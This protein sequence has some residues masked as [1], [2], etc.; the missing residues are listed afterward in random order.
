MDG[1]WFAGRRRHSDPFNPDTDG[2]GI[3]DGMEWGSDIMAPK[4]TDGDGVPDLFDLD[5]DN[6]G[7]PDKVDLSPLSTSAH[8][9]TA[10]ARGIV[11]TTATLDGNTYTGGHWEWDA[12]MLVDRRTWSEASLMLGLEG[13]SDNLLT[14]MDL[15]IRPVNP[16]HLWYA[17]NVLDWPLDAMGQIQDYDRKTFFDICVQQAL[18]AGEDPTAKCQPNPNANGDTKMVPMVEIRFGTTLTTTMLILP[19]KATLDGYGISV[20]DL[21]DGTAA[22]YLPLQLVTDQT[23]GERVAFSTRLPALKSGA[24]TNALAVQLVWRVQAL[25]DHVCAEKDANGDCVRYVDNQQGTIATYG[26][27]WFLTGLNVTENRGVD[28]ALIYEDPAVDTN[29]Q[30]DMPLW[31]LAQALDHS[32]MSGRAGA[33]AR[34]ITVAELARRFDHATNGSVFVT[35]TWG[36]SNVLSVAIQHAAHPDEAYGRIAMTDTKALL[37]AVYGQPATPVTPTI[38]FVREEKFRTM[39][40]DYGAPRD[41]VGPGVVWASSAGATVSDTLWVIVAD[42]LNP[43][44]PLAEQVMAGVNWSSYGYNSVTR[45]WGALSADQSLLELARRYAPPANSTD[46]YARGLLFFV[47]QSYLAL[48]QGIA[49]VVE[50]NGQAL[51]D[52]ATSLNDSALT[53]ALGSIVSTIGGNIPSLISRSL[54][55]LQDAIDVDA[56]MKLAGELAPGGPLTKEYQVKAVEFA[57]KDASRR[58]LRLEKGLG[59]VAVWLGIGLAVASGVLQILAQFTNPVIANALSIAANAL[60]VAGSVLGLAMTAYALVRTVYSLAVNTGIGIGSATVGLWGQTTRLVSAAGRQR[61]SAL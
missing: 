12:S 3:P 41:G 2:D 49:A 24:W 46:Y 57:L 43:S 21:G 20:Q 9:A 30:D 15:Q 31:A 33:G 44:Q 27:E 55:E 36:I 53:A 8:Y 52:A 61:L 7:V 47:Q 22:A 59:T 38:L 42:R 54:L 5:S 32:F 26:D 13:L 14:Y 25:L 48:R 6:D 11:S 28:Y 37:G 17:Y 1:I 19:P 40:L 39:N 51:Y 23:T 35:Q 18:A 56:I 16:Q 10:D 60:S 50:V 58:A 45:A 29:K 4:D 34:D